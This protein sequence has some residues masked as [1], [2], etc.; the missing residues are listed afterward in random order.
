MTLKEALWREIKY[1]MCGAGGVW[2]NTV[3]PDHVCV[4]ARDDIDAENDPDDYPWLV[5][6]RIVK[7]EHSTVQRARERMGF[8]AIALLRHATKNDDLLETMMTDL[9]DHFQGTHK[10]I[11]KFDE[12]GTPNANVGL[13]VACE[14]INATDGFSEN[15][16]EKVQIG[17]FA[18][19][20][21]RA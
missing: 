13:R 14:F 2:E 16:E 8:A 12:D 3:D 10:T 11:G 7:T 19:A 20:Y 9:Q 6:G 17:E 4:D 5:I 1:G 21:N 15:E 18:F